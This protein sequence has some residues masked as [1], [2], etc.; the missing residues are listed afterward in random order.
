MYRFLTVLLFLSFLPF[1]SFSQCIAGDCING[2]GTF[3]YRSGT[4]YVG[5][6]K[7]GKKSGIGSLFYAD[8]SKYQGAWEND[9]PNGEGI[10]TLPDGSS[11]EGIW[12]DGRLVSQKPKPVETEQ[13]EKGGKKQTGCISGDC[14]SG[15]GI[16]I[17]PSGAVYIGDFSKGEVHG[18]GTCYYADG[19]KYQ[20][21]WLHRYPDGKG[22][23]TLADGTK[24]EGYWKKGQPVD[25]NGN[26]VDVL[27]NKKIN[28]QVSDE[29]DIQS[30][31]VSGNCRNGQGVFGYADGSRYE[32]YFKNGKPDLNGTFYYPNGDKYV[33]SF[34]NGQPNGKG[35]LYHTNGK[36]LMGFWKDGEYVGENDPNQVIAGCV[37]GNC[38]NGFG[39]YLFKDGTKYIGDFKNSLPHGK[40]AVTYCNGDKYDGQMVGG[41]FEG[42]GTLVLA[43]GTIVSGKWSKGTFLG[44]E[45]E[46]SQR[47]ND[48]VAVSATE[49][50]TGS[51]KY[52]I[53]DDIQVWAVVIG[54]A[55]YNHMPVL[56]YTDDDAYRMYAF[57]K[58]PEGGALDDDHIRILIDE[59]AT[60]ENI[61]NTMNDVYGKAGKNDL[62]L[63]YFSGHGLRGSFLPI[64]FDGFNNKLYH[65][66]INRIFKNSQAKLKLC[67]A[68]ACHSGSLLASRGD[69]IPETIQTFYQS[70]AE[71][72]PGSALLMSSKSDETSLESKGLRQG[73]FSH[74]L[75][76]GLKGEAD[77]NND[78]IVSIQELYNFIFFNVRAYTGKRQSPIIQ[79]TYDQNMG[80]AIRRK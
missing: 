19:S 61:L 69:M 58:S 32:G 14:F 20:G 62:I 76:R 2:S 17:Y 39:T 66:E 12:S 6:F 5:Q 15:K 26:F 64:D 47:N 49:N 54:V 44:K 78:G 63:L 16:Y 9:Q 36:T 23:K 11:R 60:R 46:T 13:V 57:F 65:D 7:S 18:Y 80:I 73:V 21:S 56:R 45:K 77:S 22:T 79:G 75:I 4:K 27:P 41:V 55:Q 71:A 35:R 48:N 68:D 34:V 74:F 8:G 53:Q 29:L 42:I 31:C 72:G 3:N 28:T 1:L 30:G 51:G 59:D 52:A 38:S 70:L 67:I 10:E 50:N 24:I 43:D 40:G 37:S 33:G 25:S